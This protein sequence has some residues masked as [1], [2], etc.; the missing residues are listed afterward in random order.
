RAWPPGAQ[1][2][3]GDAAADEAQLL[4]P[5]HLPQVAQAGVG[6]AGAVQAGAQVGWMG[7][8]EGGF[9]GF[10]EGPG[11]GES[12]EILTRLRLRP[13]RCRKRAPVV[14]RSGYAG[15]IPS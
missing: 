4:H 3:V 14:P 12:G 1:P 9:I 11:G 8:V 5:A 13:T 7:T 15:S 6:D 10:R 2:L